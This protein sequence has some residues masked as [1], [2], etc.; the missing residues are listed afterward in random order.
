MIVTVSLY[1]PL[2]LVFTFEL[3]E[4]L[5][6]QFT[7]TYLYLDKHLPCTWDL[8]WTTHSYNMMQQCPL[9]FPA[10]LVFTFELIERQ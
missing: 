2:I 7:M 10:I 4:R 3:N 1:D 6:Y 5:Q 8:H 9:Y